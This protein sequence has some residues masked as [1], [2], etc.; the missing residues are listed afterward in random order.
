YQSF[1]TIKRCPNNIPRSE[2]WR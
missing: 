1:C 2:P